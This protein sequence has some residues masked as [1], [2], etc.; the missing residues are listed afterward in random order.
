MYRF[1]YV[2]ADEGRDPA[3]DGK[4]EITTPSGRFQLLIEAKRSYVSRSSVSHLLAWLLHLRTD[5][6]QRVI[7]FARHIPRQAAE[8]PC[9]SVISE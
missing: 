3:Y 7:L 1:K 9:E 2:S 8:A 6:A 5:E 4:L